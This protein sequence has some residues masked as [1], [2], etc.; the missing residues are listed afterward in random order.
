[1]NLGALAAAVEQGDPDRF[2]ATMAAPPAAR[3]RLWPLY[4]LNL[5]IARAP[6]ASAEPMVAE[7][8]LQWWI[9]AI[10]AGSEALPALAAIAPVLRDDPAL[11]SLILGGAE[12]RRRDAWPDPFAGPED[13]AAYLDATSGNVMWAA[14]RLLGAPA[15][16]EAVVRDFAWGAGLA[17]WLRAIPALEAAGRRPLPDGRARA[18]AD[19]AQ[20]G[21]EGIAKARA[22]RALVPPRAVPA[23]LTGWQ[24]DALLARAARDPA[25][26]GEGRLATS[27]ARRRATL[28]LRALSGR[29]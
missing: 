19:L 20:M 16:A 2:A 24:A 10:E 29:W 9:D 12:A 15:S 6:W 23:L 3:A 18:V 7:M 5:E 25:S 22:R 11:R 26:V 17:N 14:A 27:E 8:R 4:A 13:L 21:R 28:A 1:M